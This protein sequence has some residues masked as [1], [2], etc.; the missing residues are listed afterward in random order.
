M[1]SKAIT[2]QIGRIVSLNWKSHGANRQ[3]CS[4]DSS[5]GTPGIGNASRAF[6]RSLQ[7]ADCRAGSCAGRSEDAGTVEGDPVGL[8]ARTRRDFLAEG[9]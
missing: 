2:A 8:E 1:T 5:H 4:T 9:D 7:R 3:L 6:L